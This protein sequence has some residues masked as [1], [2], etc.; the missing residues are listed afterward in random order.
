MDYAKIEMTVTQIVEQM[1]A[2]TL[3]APCLINSI[4]NY[5]DIIQSILMRFPMMP[6]VMLVDS[7]GKLHV[8]DGHARIE[9]IHQFVKMKYV[10]EGLELIPEINGKSFEVLDKQFQRRIMETSFVVYTMPDRVEEKYLWAFLKQFN[11]K[12]KWN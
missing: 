4:E 5:S 10:L 3:I 9:A 7:E 11:Y 12:G 2:G 1:D 6:M 8:I